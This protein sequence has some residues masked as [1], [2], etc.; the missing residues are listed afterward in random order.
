[1]HMEVQCQKK[2]DVIAVVVLEC[3]FAVQTTS[4]KFVHKKIFILL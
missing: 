4:Q 1:M 2:T 3:L